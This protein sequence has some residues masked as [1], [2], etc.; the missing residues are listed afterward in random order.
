MGGST[1][2]KLT[3]IKT[4]QTIKQPDL[5]WAKWARGARFCIG[6]FHNFHNFHKPHI[7]S[8]CTINNNKSLNF[9]F[10]MNEKRKEMYLALTKIATCLRIFATFCLFGR[11]A[12]T[13]I[14]TCMHATL[15]LALAKNA[16][17]P[18]I[19]QPTN[20]PTDRPTVQHTLGTNL[21]DSCFHN[22]FSF[23]MTFVC[24]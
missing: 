24:I 23:S 16:R 14:S 6:D 19:R 22:T 11:L 15:F 8:C 20:Q 13:I 10:H 7:F 4:P 21:L 12:N 3:E 18:S 1:N 17:P 5:I 2:A 9:Y